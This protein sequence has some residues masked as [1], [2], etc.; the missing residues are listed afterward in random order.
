[1]FVLN[2]GQAL[3]QNGIRFLHISI[4]WEKGLLNVLNVKKQATAK[5]SS[6]I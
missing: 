4:L 1:M 2:V 3:S 6:G 5:E